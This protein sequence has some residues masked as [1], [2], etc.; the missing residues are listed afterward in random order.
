VR[1]TIRIDAAQT[2]TQAISA[3]PEIS[4]TQ[5]LIAA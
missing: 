4:A 2:A 1:K 5:E 3:T